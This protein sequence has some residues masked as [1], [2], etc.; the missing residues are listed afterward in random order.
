VAETRWL[1]QWKERGGAANAANAA[2]LAPSLCL[3]VPAAL[4]L[5]PPHTFVVREDDEALGVMA[6]STRLSWPLCSHFPPSYTM[7][8]PPPFLPSLPPTQ[9]HSPSPSSLLSFSPL[10]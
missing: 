9:I 1:W 2:P 10:E 3:L 5:Q 7:A 4:T 8:L 6:G